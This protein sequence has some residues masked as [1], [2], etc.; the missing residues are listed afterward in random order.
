MTGT[1]SV[2]QIRE[3]RG[4]RMVTMKE[5]AESAGVS[6][7]TVSRVLNGK[8]RGR[9]K[10]EIAREIK[11]IAS[12]LKTRS[13]RILGF[14]SDEIATTPFA[15]RI[16]LGAQ[17]AARELGYILLTVNTGN[18][19]D[20]ERRQIGIVRQ[21]GADGFLYAMMYHRKVDVP[22]QLDDLPVVL[23]D[24]EDRAGA[25][26]S[27][28]PD[29]YGIG[30]TATRRLLDAG[31]RRIAYFGAD[32][33]IVAQSERL[34]GYR[35]ALDESPIGYD[36]RLVL[37]ID[38][39]DVHGDVPRLFDECRPDGVFC[40]NDVRAHLA[41]REANRLGLTVGRDLSVVGVD[42]QPFIAGILSPALTSVEL[43]HYEMGYWSVRKLISLIDAGTIHCGGRPLAA[44]RSEPHVAR[45]HP[46]AAAV[47]DA[48]PG[49]DLVRAGG[50]GFRGTCAAELI[51]SPSG[52]GHSGCNHPN[53]TDVFPRVA[54]LRGY[55]GINKANDCHQTGHGRPDGRRRRRP[56]KGPNHERNVAVG[57]FL[58]FRGRR[59]HPT[60]RL[61]PAR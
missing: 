15:G 49:A 2:P 20:L 7:A 13:S 30:Y 4:I 44:C 53:N 37:A 57:R 59:L 11:R 47:I 28:C 32:V 40:F 24:A 45:G 34:A 8:D 42:N 46:C 56:M 51:P 39:H 26:P 25:R 16:M 43:P 23:V 12:N 33:P 36:D 9:I 35:A 61:R 10:P 17:D 41:Y 31:C 55:T 48:G 60:R 29:E 19:P 50:E 14:I 3:Q 21:Y 22:E 18:D 27:I 52:H 6:I 38:E 1:L 5:V 58:R 54:L